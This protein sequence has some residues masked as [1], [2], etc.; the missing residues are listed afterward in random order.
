MLWCGVVWCDVVWCGVAWCGVVW[1]SVVCGVVWRGVVWCGVVWCRVVSCGEDGL[2]TVRGRFRRR[3][4]ARFEAGRGR[5]RGRPWHL[6]NSPESP[7]PFKI[8]FFLSFHIAAILGNYYSR[9]RPSN[10]KKPKIWRA[11]GAFWGP[12]RSFGA[13]LGP[14][15]APQQ[16]KFLCF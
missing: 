4:R 9:G 6:P 12:I 3:F 15:N 2:R 16:Y 13:S 5:F 8:G 7:P 10:L 11:C 14:Q 1:C